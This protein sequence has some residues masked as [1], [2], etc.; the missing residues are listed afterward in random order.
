MKKLK[1]K[2]EYNPIKKLKRNIL[3]NANLEKNLRLNI[4]T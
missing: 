1:K 4:S 2:R 3:G